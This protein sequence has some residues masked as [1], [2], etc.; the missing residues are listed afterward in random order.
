MCWREELDVLPTLS[1]WELSSLKVKRGKVCAP[2]TSD[3]IVKIQKIQNL[4]NSLPIKIS[5]LNCSHY[6]KRYKIVYNELKPFQFKKVWNILFVVFSNCKNIFWFCNFLCLAHI[7][8][9]SQLNIPNCTPSCVCLCGRW[10]GWDHPSGIINREY[11]HLSPA[12]APSRHPQPS[13]DDW[14]LSAFFLREL[15][16]PASAR[17]HLIKADYD[18]GTERK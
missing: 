1:G 9:I 18:N 8:L 5:V 7:I 16:S 6:Y 15:S 3:F 11:G 4:P 10:L 2:V 14:L 13:R 12:P 17:D